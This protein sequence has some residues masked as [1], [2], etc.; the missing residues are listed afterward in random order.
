MIDPELE[1]HYNLQA[2]RDDIADVLASWNNR[3]EAARTQLETTLD[4]EYGSHAREKI[5]FFHCGIANA[6]LFVFIHGGYWQ[7]LGK[8]TFSLIAKPFVKNGVNVALIEYPLCPEVS[9]TQ[10][11][12]SI[13]KALAWIYRNASQIGFDR[14][15]INLCGHSAG[16]HLTAMCLATRWDQFA[17]DL[18]VNMIKTGIPFSGL[19]ELEPLV[20]TSIGT[21]LN[22]TENEFEK[23]SPI[24]RTA[25]TEAPILIVVGGAETPAFFT[26]AD[27]FERS[28]ADPELK[29][30]QHIEP[31]ADHFDLVDRLADANSAFF[32]RIQTWLR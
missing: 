23:C 18:P 6:P 15:R 31:G 3:S 24:N 13:R 32:L 11:I 25:A 5:D 12:E 16:G 22:L 4:C 21:A 27:D 14:D 1:S 17:T 7:R 10:L 9:M 30:E 20:K 26:Q 2:R 8:S 29:I 19:Y 28:W